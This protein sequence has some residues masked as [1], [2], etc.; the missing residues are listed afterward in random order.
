MVPPILYEAITELIKNTPTPKIA[1]KP[2]LIVGST[3]SELS[4]T[5]LLI[6]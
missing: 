6:P 5:A 3:I 2:I 1:A 4:L